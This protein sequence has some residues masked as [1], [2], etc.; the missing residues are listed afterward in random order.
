MNK[1]FSAADLFDKRFQQINQE[2]VYNQSWANGTG[3]LNWAVEGKH[4]VQL[5][6][7]QMAKSVT[8]NGR[9][10]IFVGTLVG[11]IAIFERVAGGQV[12]VSNIAPVLDQ[13]ELIK[14]GSMSYETC[15]D[16]I[17]GGD[18]IYQ[19]VGKWVEDIF[20]ALDKEPDCLS[21]YNKLCT[22]LPLLLVN[23]KD[24]VETCPGICELKTDESSKICAAYVGYDYFSL[25]NIYVGR[26][27]NLH[28][29]S[30]SC[31]GVLRNTPDGWI[32]DGIGEVT[33]MQLKIM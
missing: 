23:G 28:L 18:Q 27:N 2:L 13:M 16:A 25:S 15:Y 1:S 10:I 17:G 32:Y 20:H 14:G 8:S 3:Y 19:G 11:P 21:N 26:D 9:R 29:A 30:S 7:N 12:I 31:G 33:R 4:Q 6:S 22:Q 24:S 5:L